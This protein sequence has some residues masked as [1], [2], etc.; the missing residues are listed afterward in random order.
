LA[1]AP[2]DVNSR[3]RRTAYQEKGRDF[4]LLQRVFHLEENQTTVRR[5]LLAGLTTFMTMAYVVVVNPRILSESG[6]PV[7]GVLLN[8]PNDFL[9]LL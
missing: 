3:S 2:P 5:E 9:I 6:M 4:R 7:D 8:Y 1:T